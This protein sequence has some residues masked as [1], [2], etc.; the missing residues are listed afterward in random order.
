MNIQYE[1]LVNGIIYQLKVSMI[2]GDC[3]EILSNFKIS[4]ELHIV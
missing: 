2:E 4:I 1:K 3:N